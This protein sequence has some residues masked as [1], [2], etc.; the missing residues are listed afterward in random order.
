WEKNGDPVVAIDEELGDEIENGGG[1]LAPHD[2]FD[3]EMENC[4]TMESLLIHVAMRHCCYDAICGDHLRLL[5]VL[6]EDRKLVVLSE[7]SINRGM[8]VSPYTIAARNGN[9]EMVKFLHR[10]GCPSGD[11]ASMLEHAI[12]LGNLDMIQFVYD[13]HQDLNPGFPFGLYFHL[14][15]LVGEEKFRVGTKNIEVWKWFRELGVEKYP[16]HRTKI[17]PIVTNVQDAQTVVDIMGAQG[18]VDF[19]FLH[20]NRQEGC[21]TAAM[22]G[23]AEKGLLNVVRYLF[24]NR[25]EG[26][27]P[28]AL[29]EACVAMGFGNQLDDDGL[30]ASRGAWLQTLA[31]MLENC[32]R[33]LRDDMK[34][35]NVV[36]DC[37]KCYSQ[38]LARYRK[39]FSATVS[40]L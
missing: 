2:R 21:T 18:Q 5:K 19:K 23:A 4:K 16:G 24:L 10:N 28:D 15:V 29:H 38:D 26:C 17:F 8:L 7:L 36:Q 31:F 39:R 33:W 3:I 1:S 37:L 35:D 12:R 13:H 40:Y 11:L 9:F 14:R 25:R 27:S 30:S 32:K 6:V 22:D 20:E 34:D